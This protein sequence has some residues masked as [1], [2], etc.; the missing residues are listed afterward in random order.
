MRRAL[1]NDFLQTVLLAL[2]VLAVL[3]WTVVQFVAPCTGSL[4]A[5]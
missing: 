2:V 3:V 4:F 5:G 1:I